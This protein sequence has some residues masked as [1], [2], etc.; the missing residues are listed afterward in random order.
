MI[1]FTVRLRNP[2]QCQQFRNIANW[3]WQIAKHKYLELQFSHYAWNWIEIS[4]DLNWRGVDHAGPWLTFNLFGYTVDLRIYDN[5]HWNDDTND[6][7][8]YGT[9]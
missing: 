3:T 2:F 9:D 7:E 4:V 5:R 1:D 6:W 8:T